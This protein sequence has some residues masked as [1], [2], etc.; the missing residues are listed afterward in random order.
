MELSRENIFYFILIF[1]NTSWQVVRLISTIRPTVW[2]KVSTMKSSTSSH[3]VK[4]YYS[5]TFFHLTYM[6]NYSAYWCYI[7]HIVFLWHLELFCYCLLLSV[8]G[9]LLP[10]G[11]GYSVRTHT[12]CLSWQASHHVYGLHFL[13]YFYFSCFSCLHQKLFS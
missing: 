5:Y 12:W 3:R 13:F 2:L 10:Y 1:L 7:K 4:S 9:P 6:K 8:K 11:S